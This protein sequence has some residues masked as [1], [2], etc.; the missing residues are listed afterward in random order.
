MKWFFATIFT[1]LLVLFLAIAN[2]PAS[3]VP[4]ALEEVEARGLVPAGVPKFTLSQTSGSIW[5]GESAETTLLIDGVTLELGRFSWELG[6][7]AL[8]DKK[9]SL[10]IA[11]QTPEMQLQTLIMATEQGEVTLKNTEGRLPMSQ[12]EPWFP[13]LVKGEIAFVLDH[14]VFNTR[15]LLAL[16][17]ILNLEY[18]DWLGGEYDTP[19]GSYMAQISMSEKNDVLIQLNDFDATLG[20]DGL[21][22]INPTGAYDFQA[23]LFP[24]SGLVP[25]VAQTINFF[26]RRDAQGNIEVRKRGVF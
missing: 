9:L 12:F 20:I 24:R 8:L 18:V 11:I 2:A 4:L 15:Q 13:M 16:D 25:D 7:M 5:N 21:V 10:Q 26:G 14:V 3:L 1:L 17:G 23:T 19:L 6:F 22:T